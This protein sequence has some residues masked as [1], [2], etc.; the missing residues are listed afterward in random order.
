[1][2]SG[3]ILSEG[4]NTLQIGGNSAASDGTVD[5]GSAEG[6]MGENNAPISPSNS[7]ITGSERCDL[8]YTTQAGAINPER[9]Q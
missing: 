3:A 5:F 9:G 7:Q 4:N 6:I 8:T 1:M 2:A